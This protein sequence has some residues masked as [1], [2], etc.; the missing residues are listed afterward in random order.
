MDP[1]EG[2]LQQAPYNTRQDVASNRGSLMQVTEQTHPLLQG[3]PP[4]NRM[5]EHRNNRAHEEVAVVGGAARMGDYR[6][7]KKVISGELENAGKRGPGGKEKGWT[8]YVAEDR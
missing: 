4:A 6:F 8:D 1:P 5:W 3:R 7:P 2:P